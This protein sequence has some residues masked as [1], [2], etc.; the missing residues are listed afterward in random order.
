[1]KKAYIN[2][3][4]SIVLV[5]VQHIIATSNPEGFNGQ[6]DNNPENAITTDEMLSRRKPDIWEEEEEED[7]MAW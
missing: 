4:T 5:T 6:L 3:E 2:P 7:N 1:M